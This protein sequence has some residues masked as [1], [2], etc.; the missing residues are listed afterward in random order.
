MVYVSVSPGNSGCCDCGD[1][2]AWRLPVNCAIHTIDPSKSYGRSKKVAQLPQ[3]LVESIRMT[4]GRAVDYICDVISCSPEQLRLQKTE[5]SIR[6]DE[7]V[8]RLTSKWY[9]NGDAAE[10]NLEY[11]LLLW[12]DEK[13]TV[14]EV[15]NQL[16]RACKN[17][18]SFGLQKANEVNDM[19]RSVVKYSSD[20]RELLRIAKIIEDI[21]VTVTIRSARDTFRE[22]MCGTI[23]EWL[24]DIAG[25]SIGDD[26]DILRQTICEEMLK[27]WRTGSEACNATIGRS[28]IDDHE[29]EEAFQDRRLIIAQAIQNEIMAARVENQESDEDLAEH[30]EEDGDEDGD[31]QTIEA[32]E[33]DE[34]L[35]DLDVEDREG[36]GDGDL[37]MQT[38]EE[39]EDE[40]EVSEATYAGYPP[41]PPPPPPQ[42]QRR[43]ERIRTP[44]DSDN[45]DP[46]LPSNTMTKVL[47]DIPQTPTNRSRPSHQRAPK[48]WL[49]KP[50]GYNNRDGVPLYEDIWQR[51]RLDWMILFDLRLWKKARTDLRDLYISTVVTIPQ[52]KRVLGLRFAGLY[53]T[54]A[55]LYLIADREPDHSIINLSLQMLTTPSITEE[56][57]ERGN[58]LTNLIAILYTFLTT[59][60]VGHPHD[61]SPLATLA[62][63][64]GS[65]TNRRMYHFFMDLKYLFGSEYVQE[66]LR[67]E[68]RYMLQF[69]DLVKLPQGICPNTRAIGEHV[70][71]ETD[72]WI[73]ASL[74][75]RE[76]NRLCRQ[77]AESFRWRR[78]EDNVSITRVIRLAAKTTIVNSIGAERKRFHQAEIKHEVRFKRLD[79]LDF[80]R[81]EWG[82]A[83][84]YQVVDFIVDKEPI[85][86]HH[87][88]HYTLS[89]LIDCGKSM[90]R[91]DLFRLLQFTAK[92]LKE[93]H[94]AKVAIPDHDP[95]DYLMAIFDFPLRVCAWLAQMKAGMWV[96]NG[97]SLRH[98]MSTYRGVSQRDLAHH[99]DIFLLQ[100]ALVTCSPSRVLASMIDRFG[101][102]DWMKGNYVFRPRFEDT[103]L[104]DVAEDLIQ[105]LIVLLSD[106]TSLQP[107]EDEP[108]QQALAIRKDI[109]HILCFKPLSFSDLC[110]RLAD[111]FQDLEEFQDILEEM[112]NFRGPEGLSDSGTFELKQEFL[113]EL[114]PYIAHYSKN[115][116]DEAETAYRLW[117]A[118]KIGRS[119]S[120]VVYEPN[121]RP[122]V[123]GVFRDLAAFTKST[124]FAQVIYYSLAYALQAKIY[125]PN[126]PNTRVEAFIQVVLHLTLLAVL[127]DKT[128]EDE[129][130][131]ESLQSF[132]FHVLS[133]SAKFGIPG[134]PTIFRLLQGL[135]LMEE[136]KSCVPKIRLILR[137][138]QQ[139]RPRTYKSISATIG[140]PFDRMDSESPASTTGDD[141]ERKKKQALERQAK[142]MAQFQLQQQKFLDNQGSID[143]GEDDMPVLDPEG[144]DAI[145]EHRKFWTYPTGTCILCQEETNDARLFG[146]FAFIMDSDIL[147]QTNLR[148]PSFVSEV[149]DTPESLD[150]SAEEIRPFGISGQNRKTVRKLTTT[151]QELITERQGLGKGFPPSQV[152]RGPVT[153][154]CGHIMHYTC[155]ELY[156]A[157]TQRR[158]AHQIARNHPERLARK[159]FVCPLCKALG[160]AFLPIIWRGKEEIYPGVLHTEYSMNEWLQSQV[161]LTV[162]RFQKSAVPDYQNQAHARYQEL[163]ATYASTTIIPPLVNKLDQLVQLTYSTPVAAP[164]PGPFQM[165]GFF[166][167]EEALA[168]TSPSH[169]LAPQSMAMAE[170]VSIYKR[171]CD[172]F[173]V[174]Q[175]STRYNYP[176]ASAP[177]VEDLTNTD[178]LAKTL[179]FSIAATEIA[180]RGIESAPGSTLLDKVPQQTLTHL[181]ILSE[182][183]S[184][185]IAIGGLRNGG[186]NKTVSEFI[187]THV[188]Q[189]HQ[190]LFGHPQIF[191]SGPSF[192]DTDCLQPLLGQD[193]FNFLAECSVCIIPAF[194]LEVHHVLELCYVAE[195]VKVVLAFLYEPEGLLQSSSPGDYLEH[196]MRSG[197]KTCTSTATETLLSFLIQ[198]LT[199]ADVPMTL[200]SNEDTAVIAYR[201]QRLIAS[202]ALPFLR[203]SVLLLHVS[204]GLEFPNTGYS[205]TDHTEL[206]RLTNALRLPTLNDICSS[207]RTEFT[208]PTVLQYVIAGWL[209][210]WAWN[211]LGKRQNTRTLSL[212]HPA[213]FELIGLPNAF[214]TLTDETMRRK[215]PTTGKELVDPTIC[216][217]CGDIFCSQAFCCQKGK[218]GGCNQHLEKC[219]RGIGLFINIRKCTVLYLHNHTGSWAF[220]PYLDKHGEVD[221]GL[222]RNRQLFLNQKRYD[223]LLR[224]VWLHHGIPTTISRKLEA[225]INNGGWESL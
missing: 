150:R 117:K 102:V 21:K 105:L 66:K 140:A 1:A 23:I 34:M 72:A 157:A 135:S 45:G 47:I 100:T 44:S 115:Q 59:R 83:A 142:V 154:G 137:R 182:T 203:K 138:L 71:Y 50:A 124:L 186:A 206:D 205:D 164:H 152:R 118:K 19:G 168:V 70:E 8:S 46:L 166:P 74:L 224:N 35:E 94:T 63:D 191:G 17:T 31:S 11:A 136:L 56:V 57:V 99:R 98:Q 141:V 194:G 185:Y 16:A 18:K 85:S 197:D 125:T 76:I 73:S 148:D 14:E 77:F 61:I 177:A 149:V 163:F 5:E 60:Q 223:A 40:T 43:R 130:T 159:E 126:V 143:W 9:G 2:E 33:D 13:H 89:W 87:A 187:E 64:A 10:D 116:R 218:L 171:L 193:P 204:Y 75:T 106:R 153:V 104:V 30:D 120:D 25:C 110:G 156:Y 42:P 24:V 210:H 78:N 48:Y 200:P 28:G 69:L 209:R 22:Q 121:L 6:R 131:E 88:L 170:L 97:L 172:T 139:K 67:T 114:D 3:E 123:S 184:S 222:R 217:F 208:T 20:I 37:D 36:D 92:E 219:G 162:S 160:N 178:T 38:A 51:V 132:V 207:L 80:D 39:P 216:L 82:R 146:T 179:G 52:F 62:F 108:C 155:F 133:K 113:E 181:R 151:G 81:D 144:S 196:T 161:G 192:L 173:R 54:L 84:Q 91:D 95:E 103:Q 174:N 165:P 195:I 169:A 58:F 128:D 53:T 147:R 211:R 188:R 180:Q 129:M 221:P 134:Y 214:D 32:D 167:I 55:Q 220:A 15:Q 111:K 127:E 49:E 202:Y 101:M 212:S 79:P 90:S 122:I 93:P 86:F 107:I 7:R 158:Q 119:I 199:S 190:L 109:I 145:K 65:V 112:T 29:I 41:P 189:L 225:D 26:H 201:L 27:L 213:I 183:A 176:T 12:N 68:E 175:L 215:C 4:I 198:M 96:R